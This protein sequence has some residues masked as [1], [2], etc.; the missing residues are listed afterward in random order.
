MQGEGGVCSGGS[1]PGGGCLLGGGHS[2]LLFACGNYTYS[3][4]CI[5]ISV[6]GSFRPS[7]SPTHYPLLGTPV[8]LNCEV[9]E[10]IPRPVVYWTVATPDNLGL[11]TLHLEKVN[12]TMRISQDTNGWCEKVQ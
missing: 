5:M 7:R 9:P 6:L 3:K 8:T 11:G 12:L 10:S 2:I 1:A 4:V